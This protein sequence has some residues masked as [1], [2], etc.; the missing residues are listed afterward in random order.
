MENN[1]KTDNLMTHDDFLSVSRRCHYNQFIADFYKRFADD[2]RVPIRLSQTGEIIFGKDEN[3]VRRSERVRKC[4]SSWTF[5][6]Y[7]KTGYKNLVRVDRCDDRFCLNCQALKAD[8]RFVQYSP[9]FDQ[10]TDTNDMYHVVLT[11]PNVDD[12]NLPNTV[13]L[14]LD[15]FSYLIRYF[16]GTKKIKG[17]DF[18][19]YGYRGAVRSLEITVSKTDGSYHPHLHC[20]F[21]L[22]KD[23]DMSQVYWNQFS[24]DRYG[25]QETRLFSEFEV[26]LQRIWCLLILR[27][28]VTKETIEG[29]ADVCDYPDGFSCRA[30]LSNGKYHE[31]FKYAIKGSFKN[32]TLFKYENFL[33]LYRAL[34]NRRCYQTYGC[35]SKYDFNEVDE[36]LGFRTP[37]ESFDLF[38]A[39]LQGE[40]IP[41]RIEELLGQIL[42]NT[43]KE[44]FKYIS[45]ATFSR[46][47]KALS[48]EDKEE[49]LEKLQAEVVQDKQLSILE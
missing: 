47:F 45:R 43:S 19:Q 18:G 32:E 34:F 39:S 36:Y 49:F 2:N 25:R 3:F 24:E 46:H 10:W 21:V 31:V 27:I 38:I 26:L 8:Q 48:E 30:D 6:F 35:L 37:D 44:E 28:K 33:T 4:C 16:N 13:T 5:D 42:V 20:I 41:K 15:R 23:L 7:K 9:I 22:E 17:V 11:V 1:V 40:E 12:D 14:M 29:I